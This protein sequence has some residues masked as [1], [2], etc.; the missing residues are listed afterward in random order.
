[1]LRVV[2]DLGNSRLKWGRL[3]QSGRL[4]ESIAL[5]L[6]E[7]AA[8]SAAWEK[9]TDSGMEPSRWAISSVNPPLARQLELFLD[10]LGIATAS[11]YRSAAEVQVP[12]ELVEPETAGADRAF[13]VAA[14]ISLAPAGRPGIVVSCGTAITIE[15]IS[16]QGI[17]QGGA[18]APGLGMSAR[19]LHIQTAQLPLIDLRQA[20][21]HW[22]PLTRPALEAGIFWG[23]VG[24]LRELMDRQT[25]DLGDDRWVFW[26]GGDAAILARAVAGVEARIEP[27]LVLIGL[28]RALASSHDQ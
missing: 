10:G 13:A 25:A 22:G 6:D 8:W 18:I 28:A 11:W 3:D 12:H 15:R 24:A 27:D 5:P 4:A 26:T 2:A 23:T 7:P 17:W 9:W 20:P 21:P 19:A 1:M 14:A 16:K